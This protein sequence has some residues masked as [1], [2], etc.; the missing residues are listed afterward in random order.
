MKISKDSWHYKMLTNRFMFLTGWYGFNISRSLC[1]YFWQVV[2]RFLSGV[3]VALAA[4]GPIVLGLDIATGFIQTIGGLGLQTFL[5][6]WAALGIFTGLMA[7]AYAI[8]IVLAFVAEG[9]DTIS[10]RIPSREKKKEPSL[11]VSYVKAKKD[12]VCPVLEF[13][14]GE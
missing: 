12:K 14:D 8:L 9:V 4:T 5:N 13:T 1:L 2:F 7:I 6:T 11:L 10:Q 3:S